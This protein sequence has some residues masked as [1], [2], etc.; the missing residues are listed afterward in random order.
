MYVQEVQ[1][2]GSKGKK[3]GEGEYGRGEIPEL[4]NFDVVVGR[5]G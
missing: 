1:K 5:T 3:W 2:I 4:D